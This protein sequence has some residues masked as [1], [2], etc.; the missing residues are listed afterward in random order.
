[1][2][3]STVLEPLRSVFDIGCQTGDYEY[4]SYAAHGYVHN[5]MYA[6]RPLE[7]LLGEALALGARMRALG[8]VNALHVHT[9]FEQLLRGLTGELKEPWCLDG[10][11]FDEAMLLASAESEGSRSGIYV[12]SIAIGLA[13]W[14]FG[15]PREASASFERARSYLDAAPSVW[16]QPIM[17]QFA[18]LSACAVADESKDDAARAEL[19]ALASTSLEALRRLAVVSKANFA[20][21]VAM[22]EAALLRVAGDRRGA[23]SKLESAIRLAHEGGWVNDVA[24]ANELAADCETD[25]AA[26]KQRLRAA[27]AGYAAWGAAAKAAEVA[28]RITRAG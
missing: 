23:L 3:L 2:P 28:A 22:V 1:M 10:E 17:H 9:P 27:R 6:G 18:A 15:K 13:R 16:H 8:R 5:A 19:V 11:D 7:P 24:L 20:H 21:R 26:A 12:L 4:A 14:F 25:E